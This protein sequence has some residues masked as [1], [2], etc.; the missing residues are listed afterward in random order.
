LG[1]IVIENPFYGLSLE[2]IIKK[3]IEGHKLFEEKW[4]RKIKGE[5]HVSPP[6]MVIG[7]AGKFIYV[8]PNDKRSI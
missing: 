4:K 5:E 8:T 3:N 6:K 7:V 2:E 1:A